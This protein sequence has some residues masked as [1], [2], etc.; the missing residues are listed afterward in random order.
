MAMLLAVFILIVSTAMSFFYLQVACQRILRRRFDRSYYIPIVN[1]I[2]LEFP[3]LQKSLD[4][5]GATV[6]Y[7]RLRV[8]LERDYLALAYLLKHVANANRRYTLEERLL[9]LYLRWTLVSL[10]ARRLLRLNEKQAILRVTSILQYFANVVGQR[11]NQVQFGTL[12][13][14]DYLLE[15]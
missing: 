14:A 10:A 3:S 8:I 2:R 5:F 7:P 4:E 12:T 9:L 15:L 13:A 11:V 6:D 1:A